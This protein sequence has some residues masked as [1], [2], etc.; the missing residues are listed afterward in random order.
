MNGEKRRYWS[1]KLGSLFGGSQIAETKKARLWS[2]GS[3]P[4]GDFEFTD[5]AIKVA[6]AGFGSWR[7]QP[8]TLKGFVS[9]K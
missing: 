9:P 8:L 2:Q 3:V 5:G 4:R 7:D 1:Q 6:K